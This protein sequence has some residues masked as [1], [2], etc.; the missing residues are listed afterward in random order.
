[1]T[2]DGKLP[3]NTFADARGNLIPH[4]RLRGGKNHDNEH[5]CPGSHEPWAIKQG[6]RLGLVTHTEVLEIQ[7]P[8]LP[9]DA[10]LTP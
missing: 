4:K 7:L 5:A 3:P 1:M 8:T 2:S 9:T 6:L 10:Q